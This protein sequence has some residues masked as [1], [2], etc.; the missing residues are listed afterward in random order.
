MMLEIS[1]FTILL[2]VLVLP[3]AVN[4]IERNL[5]VFLFFMGMASVTCSHIWGVE[6]VWSIHLLKESL[7]EPVMITAAV[8]GFGFLMHLFRDKITVYIVSAEHKIGSKWFCFVLVTSLGLLSS[9]ITAIMAS[10]ILVEAVNVLKLNKKYEIK[11]VIIGCFSI[12]LGAVL[13]PIGEPLSTIA[14][15]K[16][17]GDPYNA[18]FFF[19]FRTLGLYILPAII[20]LG[21]FSALSEPSVKEALKKN[22]LSEKKKS[23]IKDVFAYAA[24]VYVFI[25]GL[26]YL[27]TGFKPIIDAYIIK[28]PSPLLYWINT[29]SA[30]LDNA[31][32]TAAEISPQMS[33]G[34]IQYIL[35]GLL[36]S[37]GMLITGNV[38]NIIAAGRLNIKS[39]EWAKIGIP[40]GVSLM[41]VYFIVFLLTPT[42]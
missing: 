4:G 39:K 31:T 22:S 21:V 2:I 42:K 23:N 27:G 20:G 40:L 9:I 34:Q 13:T 26:V 15:A 25:M 16:L 32:L 5:E 33:L 29:I 18:D 3:V 6:P 24:R 7:I 37:G 38:P 10:I 11:L 17:K 30:V 19:L 28:L 35:M 12:G 41:A 8:I 1:L 36:I 14:I